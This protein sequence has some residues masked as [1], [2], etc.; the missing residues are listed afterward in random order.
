MFV[1]EFKKNPG[2]LWIMKPVSSCFMLFVNLHLVMWNRN[3][4]QADNG[5]TIYPQDLT[6][7]R[8]IIIIIVKSYLYLWTCVA[9][10][11]AVSNQGPVYNLE[12]VF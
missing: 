3:I 8:L 6:Q 9:N 11:F 7:C 5:W 12:T 2:K 10:G 4:I 1:E